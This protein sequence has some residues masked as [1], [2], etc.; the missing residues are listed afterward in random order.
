MEIS[1]LLGQIWG[2]FLVISGLAG[3]LW[4]GVF[5]RLY[6]DRFIFLDGGVPLVLGLV[7]VVLHNLWVADWRVVI[8]ILGWVSL[9]PGTLQ[10]AL[11]K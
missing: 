7:T 4:P 11:A 3:V 9:I 10:I 5:V 2:G 1:I 6:K 8:T